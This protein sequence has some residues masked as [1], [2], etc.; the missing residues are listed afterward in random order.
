V[1]PGAEDKVKMNNRTA[2]RSK[3]CLRRQYGGFFCAFS[4]DMTVF[5]YYYLN[6]IFGRQRA[7]CSISQRQIDFLAPLTW[8]ISLA[9][10]TFAAIK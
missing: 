2:L 3:K 10:V 6:N 1:G 7:S 9:R 5:L 8:A 4:L